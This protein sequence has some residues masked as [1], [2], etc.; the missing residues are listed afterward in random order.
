[1]WNDKD[2]SA[3]KTNLFSF[4][5]SYFIMLEC[6]KSPGY[7]CLNQKIFI[8]LL[9]AYPWTRQPLEASCEKIYNPL[10][11]D[12]KIDDWFACCKNSGKI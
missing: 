1:M 8:L 5:S 7:Q 2:L 3:K 4:A 12:W 9:N 6:K 10:T 11:L